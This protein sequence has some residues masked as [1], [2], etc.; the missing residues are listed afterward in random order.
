MNVDGMQ[1]IELVPTVDTF[2]A[3][4]YIPYPK[5][6]IFVDDSMELLYQLVYSQD[7]DSYCNKTN[8][9]SLWPYEKLWNVRL[10]LQS[11]G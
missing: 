7:L 4:C 8:T 5:M 1:W 2:G 10:S 9:K 3:Q 6:F 11:D